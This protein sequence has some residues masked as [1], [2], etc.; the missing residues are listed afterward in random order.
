MDFFF[1]CPQYEV[2]K[3]QIPGHLCCQ[4][5]KNKKVNEPIVEKHGS[6]LSKK[7]HGPHEFGPAFFTG[8]TLS[9]HQL[10]M[11]I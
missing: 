4:N 5:L 10:K 2:N 11:L 8:G 1:K 6:G 3:S 7:E 9:V